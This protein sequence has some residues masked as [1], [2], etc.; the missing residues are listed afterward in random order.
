MPNY[1]ICGSGVSCDGVRSNEKS[2]P[3]GISSVPAISEAGPKCADDLM[4][5][6]GYVVHLGDF[7]G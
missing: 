1:S 4:T 2:N 5:Y 7:S 6:L 3:H